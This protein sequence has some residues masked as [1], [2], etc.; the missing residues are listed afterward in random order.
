MSTIAAIAVGDSRFEVL[1][2]ALTY[3][4]AQLPGSNLVATLSDTSVDLT[5]FAPTDDAFGQLA[6]D[7]GFAGDPA[8]AAAV[9]AFLVGALPVETLRD[10]ILYHVSAGSQTLADIA[11]NPTVAT[12]NGATFTA[13]GTTL[14]DAEP[15]LLN[16]TL[17][18]TDIAA[19]N[20]V[21]HVIDRVLLP[22]D[23]P[24]NDAPSITEL[25]LASGGTPDTN[26]G[27]FDLLLT[28]VQAA[29][30][31]DAL[32]DPAA[33]LTV[34]A[35]TDAA[36]VALAQDLGF[37]GT[38]E[39]AA[40]AYLVEALTLLSG[41]ADPIP[42][43]TDVLLYHVAPGSLQSAQVL[44]SDTIST[45]LGADIGV[46]GLK[47]A[48][49]DL[50]RAN[51]KLIATDIQAENG[52]VHVIDGVLIPVDLPNFDGNADLVVG[53]EANDTLSTG[54]AADLIDG[55]DGADVIDAG[56]GDDFVLGGKG[57]DT[58]LGRA[59]DDTL[60]GDNGRDQI[61]GGN[62]DDVIQGGLGLDTLKGGQDADTFVFAA[63]D[64]ADTIL[65]FG[66]GADVIDLTAFGL[67][68]FD[69][70]AALTTDTAKGAL[71]DLGNGDSIL[72]AGVDAADLTA[73]D[74]VLS[75]LMA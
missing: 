19:D 22:T 70:V 50:A 1:V 68:D 9:T 64:Q 6:V 24:G 65:D 69:A 43:L 47:L 5:V 41:G 8:D 53:T 16:P 18:Q 71:I 46:D 42:L 21:V 58:L 31:A 38:D 54:S 30:L 60:S 66:R 32:A 75:T 23:L 20:G 11:A 36:F 3:V 52:I 40:F 2:S 17:V 29:G 59:G 74:F 72:L 67:A 12:L 13:E 15:D 34:F 45:L 33:D 27:D 48:D 73:D 39:G 51:P 10:V 35:P 55:N 37:A 4:D 63:G 57:K 49:G 25:V 56:T 14:T 62:G 44:A 26:S 28:A 61:R 7:L